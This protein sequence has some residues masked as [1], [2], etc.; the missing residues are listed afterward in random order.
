MWVWK[1]HFSG[2]ILIRVGCR[3][4]HVASI[5]IHS[6]GCNREKNTYKTICE[7]GSQ[8]NQTWC[9][10]YPNTRNVIQFLKQF[11]IKKGWGFKSPWVLK[12]KPSFSRNGSSLGYSERDTSS[13]MYMEVEKV[14]LSASNHKLHYKKLNQ[15]HII[16][17]VQ[18]YFPS[19]F[20]TASLVSYP[21][22]KDFIL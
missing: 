6:S 11:S 12:L 8:D 15:N 13:V 9:L 20:T 19:G 7:W 22:V 17:Y 14:Q 21:C 5:H 1:Q 4:T 16:T 3:C 10:K 18:S 2:K